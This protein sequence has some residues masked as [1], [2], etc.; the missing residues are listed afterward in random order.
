[1][2]AQVEH[3][4]VSGQSRSL[5]AA[6]AKTFPTLALE[7]A[8]LQ[9]TDARLAAVREAIVTHFHENVAQ[10]GSKAVNATLE[11][12]GGSQSQVWQELAESGFADAALELDR[13]TDVRHAIVH[14]GEKT[15]IQ[16]RQ[17]T[18]CV[19]L[20]NKIAHEVDTEAEQAVVDL[21]EQDG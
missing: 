20:I 17:A 14:R 21:E 15:R 7:V 10:H 6:V 2:V 18:E 16:R 5:L 8:L 19:D 1:M 12:F 13:W 4:K 11:R 3:T 9:Q